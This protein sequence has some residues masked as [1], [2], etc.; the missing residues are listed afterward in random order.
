MKTNI[1]AKTFDEL[2][3]KEMKQKYTIEKWNIH[4]KKFT[5]Y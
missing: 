1:V 5:K 3:N 2:K 4:Q